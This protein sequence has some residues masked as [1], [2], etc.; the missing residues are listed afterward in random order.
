MN[1]RTF[2]KRMG[3][4]VPA[5]LIL[6]LAGLPS[7]A[8]GTSAEPDQA[9]PLVP[10]QQGPTDPAELEAFLDE[11]FAEKMAEHHVPGAAF[12]LVKDGEIFLA[13][14]YG[15]ADLEN[16]VP[17]DPDKTLFRVASVSKVFTIAAVLQLVDQGL[18]N[19]DA[20]VNT[21]L[22]DWQVENDFAEPIR[23][24]YLLTHTD[25]FETRDLATF[26]LDAANLVPLGD[27]LASDLESPVQEP[28][29]MVTYGG[30]GTALAGYLVEQ[31]SEVRFEQYI[32]EHLFQPLAMQRSS[33]YQDLPPNLAGDVAVV[34]N[35]EDAD[36]TYQMAPF[37][38]VRTPPTG[39][40]STTPTDMAHFLIALLERGR[41]GDAQILEEATV[42]AMLRRQFAAHPQ[43]PGVT[44]GF[45]ELLYNDQRAILRDGS[46]VGIR[47]QIYLL[48]E[49]NLGY[50]YVQNTR[51]DELIDEL[52]EAFLNHYY[53]ASKQPPRPA[54]N[55]ETQ[56]GRFAGVYRPTQTAQHTL[57]RLE[58]LAM[59]EIRVAAN[60]DGSLTLEPLGM[61]DVYGGFEGP[62][63]W[64]E[65]APL[66]FQRVDRERYLAFG[67]DDRGRITHLFSGSGYHGSYYKIA[68][69]ETAGFQLPL[70][71][72]FA[73][74]FLS[75]L[76]LWPIGY[77]PA[78]V[79]PSARLVRWLSG[80]VSI[81][82]LGGLVGVFYALFLRRIAGFPAFAFGV[83]PLA[84]MMLG[85]LLVAAVLTIGLLVLT[86]LAWKSGGWSLWGRVYYTLVTVVALGFVLWLDYWNLLGFRF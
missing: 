9:V 21:Y 65:T 12:V 45:M 68:W 5:I 75:T 23:V 70:L 61:G 60:D 81:L 76:I 72:F 32:D 48:P 20:D 1:R 33:F 31:V 11:F 73:L 22:K 7:L 51:G 8:Q 67:E 18:I 39:G 35:Y 71:G 58:A 52:N 4:G 53:P 83:S 77:L 26:A 24:R 10:H 82:N 69:Y 34:Y 74:V 54:A 86:L 13:R 25:G 6:S 44:Y 46:G 42:Q 79:A 50:F 28:G 66:L 56:A 63:R 59:G 17:V 37:L 80:L 40:L 41:Y 19:L 36:D 29:S 64:V 27:V 16:W 78:A 49:H 62:G 3:W 38:Y 57:A 43:L 14:G 84:T 15:Y 30:Y 2:M 55:V 85:V 47:S